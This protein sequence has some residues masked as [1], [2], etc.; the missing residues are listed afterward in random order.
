MEFSTKNP[1]AMPVD[2][3]NHALIEKG[4]AALPAE[5]R[6]PDIA[7]TLDEARAW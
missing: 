2:T 5:Y 6:I 4:W 1:F 7:P 3:A